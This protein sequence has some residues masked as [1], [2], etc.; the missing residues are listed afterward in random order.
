MDGV[1]KE[2]IR[3]G[4]KDNYLTKCDHLVLPVLGHQDT[5]MDSD[6]SPVSVRRHWRAIAAV[7][8]AR[9][10]CYLSQKLLE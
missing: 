10:D 3:S 6:L 4:V 2:T 8:V 7:L 1:L 5:M 9:P